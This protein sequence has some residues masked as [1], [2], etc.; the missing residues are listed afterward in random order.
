MVKN[1]QNS[2]EPQPAA[3]AI[4]KMKSDYSNNDITVFQKH[5]DLFFLQQWVGLQSFCV[6]RGLA[7]ES[8]PESLRMWAVVV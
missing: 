2:G 1:E 5:C 6:I 7:S 4:T 3:I 8:H